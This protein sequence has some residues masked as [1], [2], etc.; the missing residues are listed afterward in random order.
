MILNVYAVFCR[1]EKY[2]IEKKYQEA[3]SMLKIKENQILVLQ[4][5]VSALNY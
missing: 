5:E 4:T 2:S 1:Q 3:Y